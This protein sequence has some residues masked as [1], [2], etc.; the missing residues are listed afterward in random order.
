M[1]PDSR[2]LGMNSSRLGPEFLHFQV[3]LEFESSLSEVFENLAQAIHKT[4][5]R[6]CSQNGVGL[7][8]KLSELTLLDDLV[9]V[10]EIRNDSDKHNLFTI[11]KSKKLICFG[12]TTISESSR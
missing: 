10:L 3:Q 8:R 12:S 4:Q 11:V 9:A 5:V 1:G 2:K 6:D 7:E